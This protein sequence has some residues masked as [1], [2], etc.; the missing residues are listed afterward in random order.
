MDGLLLVFGVVGIV[1]GVI[2]LIAVAF[3]KQNKIPNNPAAQ[4]IPGR[5]AL[6]IERL[7]QK[8]ATTKDPLVFFDGYDDLI[9]KCKFLISITGSLSSSDMS[10]GLVDILNAQNGATEEFINKWY[11]EVQKEIYRA[12]T[13]QEKVKAYKRN[14]DAISKHYPQM[15]Q[16]NT[17]L[18]EQLKTEAKK[19]LEICDTQ[20]EQVPAVD[21]RKYFDEMD[22][23]EF[24]RYCAGLLKKGGFTDVKVTSGSG[25]FGVDILAS[26]DGITYAIQ[27]KRQTGNVGNKAVQEIYSGKEFYKRH[28]GVILTNQYFT[29]GARE[30]AERTGIILWDRDK[31][32]GMIASAR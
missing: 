28:I 1:I 13:V 15:S 27:C 17:K 32:E 9:E 8:I 20:T 24:E 23:H 14:F 7:T 16:H 6:E 25:D 19:D 30:T 2:W 31:L 11:V 21:S 3:G 26:K 10:E 18:V 12:D 4:G 29:N 22:G 5:I